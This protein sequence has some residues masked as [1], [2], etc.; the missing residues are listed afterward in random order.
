MTTMTE[1]LRRRARAASVPHGL[2]GVLKGLILH[3]ASELPIETPRDDWS[4][5]RVG[6]EDCIRRVFKLDNGTQLKMFLCEL[7]D[8][9][10][11]LGHEAEVVVRGMSVTVT[12]TTREHGEPTERDRHL[13]RALDT[14][15]SEISR[16]Y[17]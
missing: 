14:S 3:E 16:A 13:A 2:Q 1:L 5:V 12:S 10:D 6:D 8:A 7:V 17:R 9:Q 4:R 15:H 11:A